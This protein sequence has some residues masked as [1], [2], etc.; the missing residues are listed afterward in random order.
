MKSWPSHCRYFWFNL[1][2]SGP[3]LISGSN[4]GTHSHLVTMFPNNLSL[5][6]EQLLLV[7]LHSSRVHSFFLI[8]LH[9]V[10]MSRQT[11]VSPAWCERSQHWAPEEHMHL[12]F[13]A[14][15]HYLVMFVPLSLGDTHFWNEI[16]L[17][18]NKLQYISG[19]IGT[20]SGEAALPSHFFTAKICSSLLLLEQIL[21]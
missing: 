18:W 4:S 14:K 16:F 17:L 5:T 9:S 6:D 13:F 20:F 10:L 21:S 3:P 19:W 12:K 11:P 2:Q 1:S 7:S 15:M 8:K